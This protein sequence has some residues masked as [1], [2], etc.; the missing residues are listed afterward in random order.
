MENHNRK[1]F[2]L[3]T[4]IYG[5]RVV[6]FLLCLLL[7]YPSSFLSF[8]VSFPYLLLMFFLPCVCPFFLSL[9]VLPSFLPSFSLP[10]LSFFPSFLPSFLPYVLSFF[11]PPSSEPFSGLIPSRRFCVLSYHKNAKAKQTRSTLED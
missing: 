1:T 9:L 4:V 10:F 11:L 7:S 3:T 6:S 5:L 8:L 2:V